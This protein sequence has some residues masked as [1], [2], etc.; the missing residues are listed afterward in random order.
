MSQRFVGIK[1]GRIKI[2]SNKSFIHS[3][4][5]I[6]EIPLELNNISN[7]ELILNYRVRDGQFIARKGI[8]SAQDLKV[9]LIGNYQQAC[10]ISTYNSHLFPQIISHIKDFR[11]FSEINDVPVGELNIDQTKISMC[12]ERGQPLDQLIKEVKNYDPDIVLISHEFGLFPNAR[13]WLSLMTQLSEYRVIVILHS[14]FPNHLDKTIVE[15]SIPEIVVHSDGAKKSLHTDKHIHASINVI[16]HGCYSLSIAS[17][18][19][20]FYRSEHTFIQSG[21]SFPYKNMTASIKAAAL[22]K[23]KYPDIF[24]TLLV[25]ESPF[26]KVGHQLYYEE[27]VALIDQLGVQNNIGIVRGFLSEEVID[28]YYRTNKAAVFPYASQPGHEVWGASGAIR[29]AA[30]KQ[31]PV[32]SS[33]IHHFSDFPSIKIDTEQELAD[34]LDRLF[35][36]PK[37]QQAQVAKQNQFIQDNSWEKVALRFIKLFEGNLTA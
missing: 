1:N 16:P 14:T 13:Y 22:L 8:R 10:G 34:A 24:L 25:S 28:A 6:L 27:L 36:D 20:N 37:L 3:E 11:L 23:D 2:I 29:Q 17:K 21:F 35:N 4:Y 18:L 31:L 33:N 32:I 7:D 19:W 26:N 5:Q 12:W 9:A 15:A 30:S